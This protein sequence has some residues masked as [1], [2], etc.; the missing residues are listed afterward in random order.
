MGKKNPQLL[1]MVERFLVYGYS[2]RESMA[3]LEDAGLGCSR[4]THQRYRKHIRD[5]WLQEETELRP[6][7]RAE[8]RAMVRNGYREACENQQFIAAS[9][10]AQIM[11]KMDG[12]EAPTRIEVDASLSVQALSPAQ[13]QREIAELLERRAMAFE[14]VPLALRA[15]DELDSE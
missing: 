15:G 5:R 8:L 11:A 1:E 3:R 12:L 13:R 2:E 14:R 9:K 10:F 7:R 6:L 4:A